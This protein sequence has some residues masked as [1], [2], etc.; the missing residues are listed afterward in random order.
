M[1]LG[2]AL[3]IAAAL[4]ALPAEAREWRWSYQGEGVAA[5]GSLT[6]TDTPNADGFYEITKI[7][8]EANGIAITG[9]QPAGTSIPGNDGYPVDGLVRTEVPQLS[10]HGF[11]YSLAD[12]TYANPF[13]GAH[14]AKPDTYAFFS[15]PANRKTS[16]PAV[17]FK[18]TIVP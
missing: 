16:E 11:A 15:D 6:T 4:V 5:S 17:T 14:F 18:A 7:K 2:L 3:V 10:L 1:K 9:L 8:G 12:G 13:Y